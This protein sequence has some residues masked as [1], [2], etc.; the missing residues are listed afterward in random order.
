MKSEYSLI[1]ITQEEFL[2]YRPPTP[3]IFEEGEEA[4]FRNDDTTMLGIIVLD[5]FDKDHGFVLLGKD[6]NSR[7][8]AI[9]MEVSFSSAKKAEEALMVSAGKKESEGPVYAQGDEEGLS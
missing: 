1:S 7:F 8:R 4:W 9:D 3:K 5:P 2:S 6:R